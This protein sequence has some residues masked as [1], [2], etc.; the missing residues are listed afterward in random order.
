ML[1]FLLTL[2]SRFMFLYY[3]SILLNYPFW[4]VLD[5]VTI[6]LEPILETSLNSRSLLGMALDWVFRCID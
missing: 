6:I 4:F 5:H 3:S 2:P 1:P